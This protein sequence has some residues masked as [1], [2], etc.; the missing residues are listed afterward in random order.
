MSK[1]GLITLA[2]SWAVWADPHTVRC[3]GQFGERP[4]TAQLKG[5]LFAG[6]VQVYPIDPKQLRIEVKLKNLAGP[7]TYYSIHGAAFDSGGRLL[8]GGGNNNVFNE[9]K[10][11][12]EY[13]LQWDIRLA[14]AKPRGSFQVVLYE[15]RR[16]IG[17]P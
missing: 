8:G 9:K 13:T 11:G 2:L 15:D 7:N 1:I 16:L 17:H 12:E 3:G 4:A 10:R 14:D 5:N 6:Q